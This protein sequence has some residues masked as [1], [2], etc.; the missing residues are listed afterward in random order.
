[1]YPVHTPDGRQVGSH[2]VGEAFSRLI[3]ASKQLMLGIAC[4]SDE[5]QDYDAV[6]DFLRMAPLATAEYALAVQRLANAREYAAR[7]EKGAAQYEMKLLT[8]GIAK[9]LRD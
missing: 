5:S 6:W 3:Q 7:G 2:M 9:G 1:M 8:R 4:A